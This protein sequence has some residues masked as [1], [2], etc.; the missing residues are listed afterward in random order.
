MN[1]T[2]NIFHRYGI[3]RIVTLVPITI[4]S[5]NFLIERRVISES[6]L[7]LIVTKVPDHLLA[8][9]SELV[10]C[11][12]AR[13][14]CRDVQRTL[15]RIVG[16]R[17]QR[18]IVPNLF[19]DIGTAAEGRPVLGINHNITNIIAE[20]LVQGSGFSVEYTDFHE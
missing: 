13:P 4:K 5:K 19:H 20:R 14:H 9:I 2:T 3:K 17:E 12:G 16:G 18:Q 11:G 6:N 7:N 8:D 1:I 15:V 10:H